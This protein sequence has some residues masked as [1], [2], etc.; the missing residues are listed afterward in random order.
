ML[1]K[2]IT[3]DCYGT[4]IDW[5]RAVQHYFENVLAQYDI[6]NADVVALQKHWENIQFTY[7]QDH[8]RPYKEVLKHTMAMAFREYGYPFSTDDCIAFSESMGNWA[9]FPE[10]KEALLELKKFTKIALIT[11]T[12]DAIID[13]TV[14]HLGIDFD[15]IIT[16][17]QA[18]V[19]KANHRG[20]EMAMERLG[21]DC[22]ELLHVGFGFKYDVVPANELGIKSC[23]VNRYGEVRPA[24]VKETFLVGDIATLALLVKGMAYST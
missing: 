24:N 1:P 22:S 11:N 9:P 16:A 5:D 8:Y 6:N 10:A 7:I 20:F 19:Y 23:W 17:E 14:K 4:I 2:A 13:K 12:D 18:G 15:E 3:F 21:V